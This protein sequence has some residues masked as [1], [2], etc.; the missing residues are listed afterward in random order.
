M[1]VFVYYIYITQT[2]LH[3]LFAAMRR[4]LASGRQVGIAVVVYHHGQEICHV[5]GGIFRAAGSGWGRD[6]SPVDGDTLFMGCSAVKGVA[7]TCLMSCVDRGEVSYQQAVSAVWPAFAARGKSAV[8]VADAVS[9]RA[10]AYIT[11]VRARALSLSFSV[12]ACVRRTHAGVLS[13][14]D[15]TQ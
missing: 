10:G 13:Q 9:H 7:A 14:C 5:C 8:T 3:T 4:Q 15:C 6:W 12:R 1:C 2:D 11:S